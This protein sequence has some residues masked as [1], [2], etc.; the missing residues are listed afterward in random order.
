MQDVTHVDLNKTPEAAP[1]KHAFFFC[2]I[3][4][5]VADTNKEP[6]DTK[7]CEFDSVVMQMSCGK[8]HA[9]AGWTHWEVH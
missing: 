3:C 1:I 4:S 5:T 6:C 8:C 2:P 7:G 9:V